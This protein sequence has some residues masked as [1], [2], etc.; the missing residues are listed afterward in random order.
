MRWRFQNVRDRRYAVRSANG[1][2]A[3][4]A[5]ATHPVDEP[6][7]GRAASLALGVEPAAADVMGRPPQAA[8]ESIF[9]SGMVSFTIVLGVVFS[10]VCIGVGLT[11]L[12]PW[13]PAL[14]DAALHQIGF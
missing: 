5:G 6:G 14:P 12:A 2:A 13:R 7:H 4:A 9:C 1:D 8:K 11:A 10:V 3:I